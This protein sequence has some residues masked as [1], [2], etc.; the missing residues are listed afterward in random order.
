MIGDN[1]MSYTISMQL[2]PWPIINKQTENSFYLQG[3]HLLPSL[4]VL[5]GFAI[6]V[7]QHGTSCSD[8][9]YVTKQL[10][11]YLISNLY[12]G[13]SCG[14]ANKLCMLDRYLG[15]G[16]QQLQNSA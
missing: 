10:N 1:N 15:T 14:A 3:K 7:Y 11:V 6:V 8:S 9:I 12:L 5:Q 13:C 4:L 16:T 2:L